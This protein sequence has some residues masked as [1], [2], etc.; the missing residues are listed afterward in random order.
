MRRNAAPSSECVSR[1]LFPMG[2]ERHP[3]PS[4]GTYVQQ[5]RGLA[6]PRVRRTQRRPDRGGGRVAS[7][8]PPAK[9]NQGSTVARRRVRSVLR[10][11]AYSVPLSCRCPMTNPRLLH[12]R[13]WSPRLVRRLL[14]ALL[15]VFG[16]SSE[17]L[18]QGTATIRGTIVE[19]ISNQPLDAVQVFVVGQN[20]STTTNAN[21]EFVLQRVAPGRITVRTIRLGSSPGEQVVEVAAGE[22][23][24][25]RFVLS[26]TAVNLSEVVVT[27]TGGA[28]EK[29]K[30]GNSLA[31]VSAAEIAKVAPVS[32]F[33]EL[34]QGRAAGVSMLPSS[35]MIGSGGSIRIRGLTS[36]TQSGDPLIYVDGVR[37][38][39]SSNGPNV[40]GQTPSRLTDLVTSD[41][42]GRASCRERV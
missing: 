23:K 30:V 40:G 35:G 1:A 39:V 17:A 20:V 10:S 27:G 7:V 5:A 41:K 28:M 18:A 31:S 15:L 4:S 9:G 3:V 42:I 19:T 38:D 26:R 37:L 2:D 12:G 21:G 13:G 11:S 8:S 22:S 16:A 24:T 6:G 33:Q 29:R 32:N 34:V 36:V 14:P 25:I